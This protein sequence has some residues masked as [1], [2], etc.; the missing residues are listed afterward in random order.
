MAVIW[1]RQPDS[2]C[3]HYGVNTVQNRLPCHVQ[4]F[5]DIGGTIVHA[6]QNMTMQIN[7]RNKPLP[8]FLPRLPLFY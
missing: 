8:V 7:Q 5:P 1:V 2:T 4:T 6:G 3:G